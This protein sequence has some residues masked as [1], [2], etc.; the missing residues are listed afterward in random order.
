MVALDLLSKMLAKCVAGNFREYCLL[1]FSLYRW[2]FYGFGLQMRYRNLNASF[3]RRWCYESS[4]D[5]SGLNDFHDLGHDFQ[6]L[7]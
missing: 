3:L 5:P 6:L 4:H 7:S 1:E 2:Y